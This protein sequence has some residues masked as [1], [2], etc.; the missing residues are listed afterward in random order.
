MRIARLY[1]DYLTSACFADRSLLEFDQ[2]L[3]DRHDRAE[4]A[5]ASPA[6]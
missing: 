4:I 6:G 3:R 5:A 2:P 1:V